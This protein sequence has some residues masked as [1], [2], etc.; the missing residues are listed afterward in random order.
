MVKIAFHVAIL[1]APLSMTPIQAPTSAAPV[2]EAKV[3]K[4][5]AEDRLILLNFGENVGATEGERV[6]VFRREPVRKPVAVVTIISVGKTHSL[7]R[8]DRRASTLRA[9]DL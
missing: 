3:L 5:Y 6:A 8:L 4:V 1:L 9:G 2:R 7:A